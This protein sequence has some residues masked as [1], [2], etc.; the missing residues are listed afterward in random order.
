MLNKQSRR[1]DGP[2]VTVV[3]PPAPIEENT[4]IGRDTVIYPASSSGVSS[5]GRGCKR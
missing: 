4:V 1:I 5:I 2:G 3:D